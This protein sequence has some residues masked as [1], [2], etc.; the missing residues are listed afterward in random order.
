MHSLLMIDSLREVGDLFPE[1]ATTEILT[2]PGALWLHGNIEEATMKTIQTND[3]ESFYAVVSTPGYARVDGR[4]H[5]TLMDA[6]LEHAPTL[7]DA[8]ARRAAITR[9]SRGIP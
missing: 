3:G 5:P 8:G 2:R 1:E 6:M 7:H 9:R 4:R